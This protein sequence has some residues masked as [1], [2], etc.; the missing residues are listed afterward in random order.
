MA[1]VKSCE[2]F[3]ENRPSEDRTIHNL[4]FKPNCSFAVDLEAF[5]ADLAHILNVEP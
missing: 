4:T 3:F 1:A 2:E 5:R